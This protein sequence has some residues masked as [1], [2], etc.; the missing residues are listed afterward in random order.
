MVISSIFKGRLIMQKIQCS[1][2]E[3][4]VIPGI[5]N[6][7]KNVL[8]VEDDTTHRTIME[9]I[10]K[11]CEFSV[12]SAENGYIALTKL[13]TDRNFDLILMDWDMPELNGLETTKKIRE[14]EITQNLPHIPIIAFT[15]NQDKGDR[16]KCIAAGMDAYLPK[17]VW[18]P[19]W[20]STLINNLQGLIAGT[21]EL[22]DFDQ[23]TPVISKYTKNSSEI[24]FDNIAFQQS[25]SLLKDEL[26]IAVEEYLEDASAYIKDIYDGLQKD[27]M[28]KVARGSHPLKSNSKGFGLNALSKIAEDINIAAEKGILEKVN[29]L[30]PQLKE[31]FRQ[32]EKE[33]KAAVKS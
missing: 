12:T 5:E 30:F 3:D 24:I 11:E 6:I 25:A 2:Y 28:R 13:K 21:F 16:E 29:D 17:D 14:Q 7:R 4:R 27:D 18:L 19:R 10:L 8:V 32:S 22:S 9:K 26:G 31:V 20:R 1:E 23:D 33:L 15:S